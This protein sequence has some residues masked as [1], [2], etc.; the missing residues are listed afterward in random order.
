M[1][2]SIVALRGGREL[3]QRIDAVAGLLQRFADELL[4]Q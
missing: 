1:S 2:I 4:Q 3:A